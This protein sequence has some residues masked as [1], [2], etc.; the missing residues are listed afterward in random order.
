[1]IQEIKQEEAKRFYDAIISPANYLL[2]RSDFVNDDW[3]EIF[4]LRLNLFHADHL[5]GRKFGKEEFEHAF[6]WTMQKFNYVCTRPESKVWPGADVTIDQFRGKKDYQLSLKTEA[7]EKISSDLIYISKYR[8]ARA[9]RDCTNIKKMYDWIADELINY[10]SGHDSIMLLRCLPSEQ[11]KYQYDL[12]EVPGELLC[13][14]FSC[15]HDDIVEHRGKNLSY[16]VPIYKDGK[17]IMEW[18][19]CGGVEK[20]SIRK[21]HVNACKLHCSWIV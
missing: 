13:S 18:Y 21:L 5:P 17:E 12:I 7:S 6:Y 20:V 14:I 16:S 8:E 9:I 19:F 2:E 15:F 1:M 3:A 11:Q 10:V 4:G